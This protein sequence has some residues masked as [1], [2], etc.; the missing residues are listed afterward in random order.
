MLFVIGSYDFFDDVGDSV[1]GAWMFI[2]GGTIVAVLSVLS[3]VETYM[4]H[5]HGQE[6]EGRRTEEEK[7]DRDGR[8]QK[9]CLQNR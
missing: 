7:E 2:V 5:S 8:P 3:L 9:H 4:H 1:L 6:E